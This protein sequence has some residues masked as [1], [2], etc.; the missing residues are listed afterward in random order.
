MYWIGNGCRLP[1]LP[2]KQILSRED[3]ENAFYKR[4]QGEPFP[5]PAKV[6]P[7]LQQIIMKACSYHADDRYQSAAEMKSALQSLIKNDPPRPP[8]PKKRPVWLWL[9]LAA[10]CCVFAA[11]AVWKIIPHPPCPSPSP[12]PSPTHAGSVQHSVLFYSV[13]S[14]MGTEAASRFYSCKSRICR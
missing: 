10:Q 13:F 8:E 5:P 1:H 14:E 9:C 11:A 6:S 3:R 12:S 7:P 4:I 2:D